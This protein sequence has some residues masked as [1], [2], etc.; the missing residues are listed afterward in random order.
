MVGILLAAVIAA[1]TFVVCIALG[2][3]VVLGVVFALV[4]LVA[5][6]PTVGSRFG[7]GDL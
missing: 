5:S 4:A 3:S 7:A 6:V 1:L 2:L